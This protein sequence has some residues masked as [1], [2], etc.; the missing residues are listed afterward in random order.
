MLSL[1]GVYAWSIFVPMLKKQLN[2]STTQTQLIVGLTLGIFATSMIFAG[3]FQK[4]FGTQ[5]TALIGVVCLFS[6]YFFAFLSNGDFLAICLSIGGL[7]GI[8][9]GFCYVCCLLVPAKNFPEHKGL[10]TGI[11]VGGFGAGAI[12]LSYVVKS[13]LAIAPESTVLDLFKIIGIAYGMIIL[14][15]IIFLKYKDSSE[16]K[17][18]IQNEVQFSFFESRFIILFIT[19]FA[20]TFGGLLIL[21]NAK[22]MAISL[23]YSEEIATWSITLLAFGNMLGRV[24]WGWALDKI[25]VDKTLLVAYSILLLAIALINF[26]AP[27]VALLNLVLVMV[28]LG[29]SSN[30]VLFAGKTAQ[31]YGTDR[32]GTIYPFIFLAYGIAGVVGP[33]VGG[34]LFDVKQSYTLAVMISGGVTL[35]GLLV[36]QLS[37][38]KI[39][40]VVG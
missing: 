27:S 37:L 34:W 19:M 23:G 35:A 13:I 10:A 17:A 21:G 22:P 3:R 2:Y 6:G 38:K 25:G 18:I 1:G 36:Y 7:C 14:V 5:I 31:I 33:L 20:G 30:F 4:R 39:N 9:T 12:L 26:I 29:F 15:C 32:L 24:L 8:G 40:L 11:A 28:G 16:G